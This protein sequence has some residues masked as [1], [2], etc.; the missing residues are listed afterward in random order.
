MSIGP[1]DL[2]DHNLNFE[3]PSAKKIKMNHIKSM[4]GGNFA[5]IDKLKG[6]TL[7]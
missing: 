2:I 4:L 6:L 3:D 5:G 7:W 1:F